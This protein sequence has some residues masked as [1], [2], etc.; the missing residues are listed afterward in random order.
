MTADPKVLMTIPLSSSTLASAAHMPDGP[1]AVVDQHGEHRS[2]L[3][4][5]EGHQCAV[6]AHLQRSENPEPHTR[7]GPIWL[8]TDLH[9]VVNYSMR[10]DLLD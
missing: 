10:Q 4:R 8:R 2:L 6:D 9:R 3:G 5:A 7:H 1:V